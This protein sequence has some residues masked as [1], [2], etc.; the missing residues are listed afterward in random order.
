M[1]NYSIIVTTI[2]CGFTITQS[3]GSLTNAV[4]VASQNFE[5][6]Y[7]VTPELT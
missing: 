5:K 4:F 1:E 7:K 2:G 6:E 3:V